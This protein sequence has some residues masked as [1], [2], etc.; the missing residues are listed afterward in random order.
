[1]REDGGLSHDLLHESEPAVKVVEPV[2]RS[3]H[4]PRNRI[5]FM[6]KCIMAT[7]SF[8]LLLPEGNLYAEIESDAYMNGKV[9]SIPRKGTSDD[10][11]IWVKKEADT[12]VEFA[13]ITYVSMPE[14]DNCAGCDARP[15][16]CDQE[17]NDCDV[18]S[19]IW[20]EKESMQE[21]KS[22]LD[23]QVGSN[24]YKLAGIQPVEY[25]HANN[26]SFCEGNVI[27]YITSHRNKNKEEDVRKALH[28]CQLILKLEYGLDE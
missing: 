19:V 10:K 17:W 13:G 15:D 25:I 5:S 28:Y 11:I 14:T 6:N 8:S 1:M 2:G 12:E 4:T 24:H 9:I 22:A 21:A 18:R 16:M 27:K 23:K 7:K 26:L 3:A 20:K